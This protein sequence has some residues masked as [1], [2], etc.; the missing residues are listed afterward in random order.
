MKTL[1]TNKQEWMNTLA[2]PFKTY[3]YLFI[4]IGYLYWGSDP[5]PQFAPWAIAYFF[6]FLAL[7]GIAVAQAINRYFLDA[8]WSSL[9]ALSALCIVLCFI[10][11]PKSR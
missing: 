4:V 3:V 5:F 9:F 2:I 11:Y 10:F 7:I 8:I 6:A 1:P